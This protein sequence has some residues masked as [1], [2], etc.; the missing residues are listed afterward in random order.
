MYI[1]T[2]K[3]QVA[4]KQPKAKYKHM[5][6]LEPSERLWFLIKWQFKYY[7]VAKMTF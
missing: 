7:R 4:G 1:D 5:S 6:D 2:K 3:I